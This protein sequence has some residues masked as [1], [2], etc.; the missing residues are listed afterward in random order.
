M[1]K[2]RTRALAAVAAVGVSVAALIAG[3][4]ISGPAL[5]SP[6]DSDHDGMPNT[7]EVAQH[8][9]AHRA[10]G[11]RDTDHDGLTNVAEYRA[12]TNPR[13]ADT[14]GDGLLDGVEVNDDNVL[15]D[16]R[17]ADTNGDG[18]LDGHE[19][20][21]GVEAS[22][23]AQTAAPTCEPSVSR[24]TTTGGA[25]APSATP[26]PAPTPAA[27]PSTTARATKPAPARPHRHARSLL[28]GE[29]RESGKSGYATRSDENRGASQSGESGGS[30]HSDD[31]RHGGDHASTP[32]STDDGSGDGLEDGGGSGGDGSDS[33]EP[34][35]ADIDSAL[36]AIDDSADSAAAMFLD[37]TVVTPTCTPKTH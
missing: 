31:G 13:V 20:S 28:D 27:R 19:T 11:K 34:S 18:V 12:G 37:E 5:A 25:P 24:A 2:A 17:V 21:G 6:R 35:D 30:G 23:A 33:L 7:W 26:A 1:G 32:P 4:M 14:D 36:P 15:T 10:N 8:F 9:N 3:L 22:P 29:D 16:P